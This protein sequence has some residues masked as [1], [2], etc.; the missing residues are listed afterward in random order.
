MQSSAPTDTSPSPTDRRPTK[1]IIVRYDAGMPGYERC[2]LLLATIACPPRRPNDPRWQDVVRA[3][4]RMHMWEGQQ[5]LPEFFA[6]PQSGTFNLGHLT[7]DPNRA[8]KLVD[9]AREILNARLAAS[10]VMM[11]FLWEGLGKEDKVEFRRYVAKET[12]TQRIQD[13]VEREANRLDELAA[14]FGERPA[15]RMP[16]GRDQT[17]EKNFL[18]KVLRPARPVLHLVAAL[19]HVME[20]MAKELRLS[21]SPAL[22]EMLSIDVRGPQPHGWFLERMPEMAD[23]VVSMSRLYEQALPHLAVQRPD[24]ETVVQFRP[25]IEATQVSA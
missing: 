21:A 9:E 20:R 4:C 13:V 8:R 19:D 1:G 14:R 24:P 2:A 6:T 3:F 7:L 16:M 12:L 17:S 25:A 18:T 10:H 15:A 5:I 11:P 22:R 23:A